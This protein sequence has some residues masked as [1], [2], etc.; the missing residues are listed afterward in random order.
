MINRKLHYIS[1]NKIILVFILFLILRIIPYLNNGIPTGYDGGIYI[2]VIKFF[3]DIPNW[4]ISQ[5]YSFLFFLTFPIK[6]LGITPQYIVVPFA[7]LIQI[8]LLYSMY[9]IIKKISNKQ[10]ALIAAFI[11]SISAIQMR[12]Y[13][14]FYLKYILSLTFF[15][16]YLYFSGKKSYFRAGF[17][18]VLVAIT[19]LL[20]F[21]ILIPVAIIDAIISKGSR[22]GKTVSFVSI[23]IISLLFYLPYFSQTIISNFIPNVANLVS[24]NFVQKDIEGGTFYPIYISILLSAVYLPLA[25]YGIVKTIKTKNEELQP[26]LITLFLTVFLIII[27]VSFFRRI[28]ILT[29]L[30]LI[31]YASIGFALIKEIQKFYIAVLI[32]FAFIFTLKTSDKLINEQNLQEI[33]RTKA[34]NYVLSTAK[35]DTAWLLGYT[36]GKVIAWNYGGYDKYWNYNQW[37]KFLNTNISVEEKVGMIKLLP[38]QTIIY[39]DDNTKKNL[40]DLINCRNITQISEHFYKIN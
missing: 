36:N 26:F 17:F 7:I 32:L 39:I 10:T 23:F 38:D 34:D 13:W 35:E 19:H 28:F 29:D 25:I 31:V 2:H 6:L 37:S 18:G 3:P 40:G 11:L 33:S 1:N 4:L 30:M 15:L 16:Y 5:Y 21:S 8:F 12:T 9:W 20:T 14:F 22:L 24:S 27:K